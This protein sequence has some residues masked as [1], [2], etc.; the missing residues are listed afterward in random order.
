MKTDVCLCLSLCLNPCLCPPVFMF[1]WFHIY[2][3]VFKKSLSGICYKWFTQQIA[4]GGHHVSLSRFSASWGTQRVVADCGKGE[5]SVAAKGGHTFAE[6]C[7]KQRAFSWLWPALEAVSTEPD[8]HPVTSL[9]CML[10]APW[11]LLSEES[12]P[13][14][15]T[16]LCSYL[17]TWLFFCDLFQKTKFQTKL[18]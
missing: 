14:G 1:T 3:H 12:A 18:S 5:I 16:H 2:L 11:P 7:I 13:G 4:E 15:R 17:D 9:I 8:R 6:C 10:M